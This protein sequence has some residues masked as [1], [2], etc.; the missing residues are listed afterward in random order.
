MKILDLDMDYFMK[1]DVHI[2]SD[3]S[4]ERLPEDDYGEEVWTEQKVRAFLE[5]NL[6]LSKTKKI[7]GRIVTGHNEALY[8]WQELVSQGKLKTPFDVVHVDTH[9]DLGLGYASWAYICKELLEYPVG[10]RHL[11]ATYEFCGKEQKEGIGDYL[12]FA[13]AYRMISSLTYCGN[14]NK[15][16]NDYVWYTLKDFEEEY[17]FA[18]GDPVRNVIQLLSTKRKFPDCNA[19][20]AERRRFIDSCVKEPEVPFLIIPR[21]EDV[22]YKGDFDFAVMA[23]SPN[24]TPASADFIM[25]VFKEYIEEI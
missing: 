16:C 10:E 5:E 18:G 8:F 1:C 22:Q 3:S 2:G 13:I 9:A 20:K 6:G 17:V 25:D 23:Q 4:I 7:P 24:Y 21:I 12:L 11:H 15:E 19:S 14:P